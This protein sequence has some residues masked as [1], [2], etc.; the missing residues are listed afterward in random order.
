MKK[1][2]TG[3]I[4]F[5]AALAL[6]AC[7]VAP[8]FIFA[9]DLEVEREVPAPNVGEANPTGKVEATLNDAETSL[10][11]TGSF[12]G[13]T[14]PAQAAHIHLGE[15]GKTGGVVCTL[16]VTPAGTNGGTLSGTCPVKADEPDPEG[17]GNI[18]LEGLRG[19]DYYVNVHTA[20]NPPGEVRAQLE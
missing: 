8:E 15:E 19:G 1:L 5:A 11:V 17:S 3:L 7:S 4:I 6:S 18:N 10:T 13:L 12:S 20:A 2:W 16:T 14:G 9:G